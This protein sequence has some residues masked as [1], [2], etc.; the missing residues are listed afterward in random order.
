MGKG[1]RRERRKGVSREK[2]ISRKRHLER[3]RQKILHK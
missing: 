2:T 3:E 1:R